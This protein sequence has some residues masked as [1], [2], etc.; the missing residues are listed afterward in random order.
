MTRPPLPTFLLSLLMFLAWS[1]TA[2]DQPPPPD[3][4]EG[5]CLECHGE[6][7]EGAMVHGALELEACDSCHLTTGDGHHFDLA[8]P[9][10]D[11]CVDCHEDPRQSEGH[12][13]GPVAAGECIA[14]HD[15]HRSQASALLR[16]ESPDLCWRCHDKTLEGPELERPI[17][18]VEREIAQAATI[19]EAIEAGCDLCHFPHAGSKDGLFTDSFPVGPYAVGHEGSYELCFG[20]HDQEILEQDPQAT[21]FRDGDRNLHALH[22]ARR[23]SR[24]CALCHSPHGGGDRLLRESVRFGSWTMPLTY[25]ATFEG[26]SCAAAC[27]EK[28]SYRREIEPP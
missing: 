1:L 12:V 22:V 14:C 27:H 3:A 7:A 25:E 9:M 5:A 18:D 26:G 8:A 15:P 19:H 10:V 20:C 24:S 2:Q 11:A 28:R 23:K 13:H 21:G 16:E 4:G 6:L 17:R